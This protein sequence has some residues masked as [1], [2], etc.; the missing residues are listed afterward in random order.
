MEIP[1]IKDTK[2]LI[3]FSVEKLI[4]FHLVRDSGETHGE[5]Y[6][7]ED[8]IEDQT[9]IS[10]EDQFNLWTLFGLFLIPFHHQHQILPMQWRQIFP[11]SFS[12]LFSSWSYRLGFGLG[13]VKNDSTTMASYIIV[14]LIFKA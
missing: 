5:P 13:L 8:E 10:K 14:S 12:A 1:I 4:P 7:F 2:T 11:P 9:F 6:R 3:P